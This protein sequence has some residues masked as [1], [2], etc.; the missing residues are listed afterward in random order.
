MSNRIKNL[1][2]A[3]SLTQEQLGDMLGVRKAAVAKYESGAVENLK[4]GTIEKMAEIFNVTP[5]F[6]MGWSDNPQELKPDE[7]RLLELFG[8]LNPLGKKEAIK[9]VA[10]LSVI[11]VYTSAIINTKEMIAAHD[12]GATPEEMQPDLLAALE[13]L[14]K[15]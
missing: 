4:R 6:V 12:G 8:Q 9:R 11:S 10:E 14:K 2:E 1:R 7:V 3:F 15:E 13:M 5:S